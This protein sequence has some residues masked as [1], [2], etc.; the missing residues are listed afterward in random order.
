MLPL[1]LTVS[2]QVRYLLRNLNE[3]NS[4]SVLQELRQYIG[5]GVEVSILVLQSCLDYLNIY[6]KD[7]KN[8]QLE[9]VFA[10]IF[11]Y[12]LERPNFTT[13]FCESL[14]S[15]A[16][17]GDF[18][19]NLCNAL[20]LSVSEKFG[21]GFALS[22]SEN[23]DIRMCG[24]NFCTA[25]IKELCDSHL[26]VDSTEQIQNILMFLRQSDGLS[27]HV[28]SFI[29]M[30]PK[31]QL[32]EDTE[33][34]LAPLLSN[35]LRE[36]NFLRAWNLESNEDEFDTL[37]AEMEKEI[38]I[39]DVMRE[40]GYR[41]TV[42]DSQCKDM[43]SLFLPLTES[44]V[45]RILGT[46]AC[47]HADLDDNQNS[48]L[49]FCSAFG[50]SS[51]SDLPSTNSWNIDV[52]VD[53]IKQ[54]SPGISWINVIENLDHEG[55]YITNEAAFCL[56]MSMYKQACQDPFP[57]GAICGS[58]WKNAEGQLSFLKYA[59]SVPPEVFT[60]A[61]SGRQ[62]GQACVRNHLPQKFKL[63]GGFLVRIFCNITA[64]ADAANGRKFQS[65]YANHAW[66]CLD[67]LEVLCQ[68]AERGHA[69]SVR[70]MLDYPLK[71]CPELL[72]LGMAHIN[73]A[74]NLLPYKVASAVFSV[75]LESAAGNRMALHIWNVN[76]NILLR[77]FIDTL[78]T[79]PDHMIKVLDLCQE[80][81][82]NFN[83]NI[84]HT[85]S[86]SILRCMKP[87]LGHWGRLPVEQPGPHEISGDGAPIPMILSPVLDLLPSSF[88]IRL[89]VLAS[90]KELV[91]LEKWLTTNLSTY[92]EIFFEECLKFLKEV[93]F[94]SPVTLVNLCSETTS[95]FLKALKAHTGLV[96][97]S[98]LSEEL[99]KLNEI[100][101]HASSRMKTGD[102]T[103]ASN[104]KDIEAEV[105]SHFQQLFSGQLT[106][107]AMIRL[108]A[109]FKESSEKREK[110]IFECMI[111]NL[112]E[113][114]NF[115]SKYPERQLKIA[116]VLFG[117][118]IKYQLVTHITLGIALRAVLDAL[119]KPAD[120]KMFVFGIM[121]LEQFLDRMIEWPQYCN[122]ILQI[123][124]LR[125][126]HMELVAFIERA[127]ARIS[128]G[129][130]EP[131]VG[132]SPPA[133]QLHA[134]LS[135]AN[136]EMPVSLFPSI[137]SSS[138]IPG[139]QVSSS[140]QLQQKHHN[141]LEERQKAS[142]AFPSYMKPVLSPVAQPPV[143]PPADAASIQKAPA[144]EIQD[145]IMFIMNNLSA[146]NVEA[147]SKE[148]A[149]FLKEQY[150][151]WFAQYLVMK[152]APVVPR[153][154]LS[155]R[156]ST[157]SA[158]IEHNHH[159]MY[160][161][162]LDKIN[163]KPLYREVIQAT[164]ENCKVLLGSELIKSSS[165]E[166]SLLKHLGSWLGKI[167]IGRNQVLRA[168]EIDPKSL[169]VEAYEKGLMIAVV[170]FTSK[171]LDACQV[172]VAYR[173]PNPWTMGVLGL[174]VEIYSMPNLKMNLKFEIE[175]PPD[176]AGPSHP[177]CPSRILS[178]YV[179][180]APPPPPHLSSG[181]LTED[182][183]LAALGLSGPLPA[184]HGLQQAQLPFSIGQLPASTSNIEQQV[185][186]N[187]KIHAL[188]LQL[189]FQSVLPLAIDRA[190]KEIVSSI[191]QR[192][193]SIATQTTKELVLKDYAMESD[194]TRIRNA[195]RLMVASLAGSLAHVTC[196]EPLRG[197]ISSQLRS[198]LQGLNISSDLLEHAVQLVTNDNLDLGCAL[199]EQA[200]TEK[201]WLAWGNND[202]WCWWGA[203]TGVLPEYLRS[204]AEADSS[205][206]DMS[207]A[208]APLERSD[209][210]MKASA[211][212]IASYQVVLSADN[213]I[214]GFQPTSRVGVNLW[215]ANPLAKELYGGKKLSP[216]FIEPGL[217]ISRPSE[218]VVL[219]LLMSIDGD[220]YFAWARPYKSSLTGIASEE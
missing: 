122:H 32:K 136:L 93:Q 152:R 170:P 34:I 94:G 178:Q 6:D 23:L 79:D 112:F 26:S 144:P 21:I 4:D 183:K 208:S 16:V 188:G 220:L 114:Y 9:P 46:V 73:T 61:H 72:L 130:V 210:E 191:V 51:L 2:T 42:N 142:A 30:L 71:H 41:C 160:L 28:D 154:S 37:L 199:I 189:H 148:L 161:K 98:W 184:A 180:A 40:M 138:A 200:A 102:G 124:H 36:A 70:P 159:D 27:K 123:S 110:S 192:S 164:Y 203:W 78:K 143:V 55:F 43:L 185:M 74:F 181:T 125:G 69:S 97:S 120:S 153:P 58:V 214:V 167:T 140:L 86:G 84:G 44:T 116:A 155:L 20:Q 89:A 106:V 162:F 198:S 175:L 169:I 62:L 81:K 53:S 50:A 105:N 182:E 151:P 60:F 156:D 14:R 213:K 88:G 187:P 218:V 31:V 145:K 15:T 49:T 174:L 172:S 131:D 67:L 126:T 1:S 190:T 92:K 137:G 82:G 171:I 5:Y 35:E 193:V 179:A 91:D 18:P 95:I 157:D 207:S 119:R 52:L 115:F 59:I 85:V 168:R 33:F 63:L 83:V 66:L 13:V 118:L 104:A 64:Y 38:S 107:D 45:A 195:A 139:T 163:L 215:A 216:G 127:L 133:D 99:E 10:S 202:G 75:V 47:T 57:L 22:D 209:E 113:E 165:E 39:A 129:H 101:L 90:K 108:L 128:S 12:I 65:G 25:Q 217:K 158:S 173:P 54:L 87:F 146:T 56:L 197:S 24:K 211:E 68:L 76:P 103:D 206:V 176:S 132:L 149:E 219:E 121:A 96:S 201:F 11:R 147:K 117:L 196:K 29:R 109:R 135:L 7:M 177:S 150:Y 17:S 166:R 48:F 141:S 212:D 186:I 134:S 204:E 80:L 3:S 111:A 19:E 205:S 100:F 8:M 77:G 194:E